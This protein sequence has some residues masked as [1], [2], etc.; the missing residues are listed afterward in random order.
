MVA[1]VL[2]V[3]LS[4]C[5]TPPPSL[6][7]PPK[8][9]FDDTVIDVNT[10]SIIDDYTID[11]ETPFDESTLVLSPPEITDEMEEKELD[12]KNSENIGTL[13]PSSINNATISVEKKSDFTKSIATYDYVD[14]YIYTIYCSPGHATDLRLESGEELL[15]S[16]VVGDGS[17]WEFLQ[18]SS[19]QDGKSIVHIFIRPTVSDV[20]T[21]VTLTTNRRTYYLKLISFETI[22]MFALQFRYPKVGSLI[23]QSDNTSSSFTQGG[24]LTPTITNKGLDFDFL[25]E[26]RQK[27]SPPWRP[28]NVYT[29]GK[30]T[31]LQL[32]P[33]FTDT[34]EAPSIYFLKDYTK[35]NDMSIINYSIHGTLYIADL[36]LTR[37]QSL[38][39]I[40]GD[41]KVKVTKL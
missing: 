22:F 25:I 14:G 26:K 24:S 36:S 34:L 41:D 30:R 21:T 33:Y 10:K 16:P 3:L 4:S 18:G 32:S 39:L 31:Y 37:G 6:P 38:M 13:L 8:A 20:S 15:S 11:E 17:R 19:I 7:E 2:A 29:D 9:Q 12:A 40:S 27:N 35:E 23:T 28:N 5:A 1:V